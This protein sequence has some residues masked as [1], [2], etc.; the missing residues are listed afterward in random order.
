[1]VVAG[2]RESRALSGKGPHGHARRGAWVNTMGHEGHAQP[3]Q[4][5]PRIQGFRQLF[6]SP[7]NCT[8]HSQEP[9]LSHSGFL[10]G[11]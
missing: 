11:L 1:M 8:G 10:W 3:V 7:C 4:E 9:Q 2:D 5:S 6:E